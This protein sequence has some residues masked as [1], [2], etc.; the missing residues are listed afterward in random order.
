MNK[1]TLFSTAYSNRCSCL[2][3]LFAVYHTVLNGIRETNDFDET[4]NARF[5]NVIGTIETPNVK[6]EKIAILHINGNNKLKLT[7]YE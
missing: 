1:W 7:F 5:A 6:A 3:K 4:Q 2:V